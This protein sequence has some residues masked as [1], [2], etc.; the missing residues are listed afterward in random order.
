VAVP[1]VEIGAAAWAAMH[2]Q[3]T[4]GDPTAALTFTPTLIVRGSTA[5]VHTP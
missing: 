2:D 4:G 5:T 1:A 3:L